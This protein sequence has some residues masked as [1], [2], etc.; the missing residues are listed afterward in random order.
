M[1]PCAC[2]P[3]E[4]GRCRPCS[5]I[6]ESML[7]DFLFTMIGIV[8]IRAG[9][10]SPCLKKSADMA[11]AKAVREF[12]ATQ[13]PE[14]KYLA[15]GLIEGFKTSCELEATPLVD[16]ELRKLKGDQANG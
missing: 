7:K 15:I 8:E 12:M 6:I 13:P 3:D 11:W 5:A 9:V 2:V 1:N 4:D 16:L 10:C 14:R